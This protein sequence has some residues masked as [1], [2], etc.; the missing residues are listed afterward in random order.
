MNKLSKA[1]IAERDRLTSLVQQKLGAVNDAIGEYNSKVKELEEPVNKAVEEANQAIDEANQWMANMHEQMDAYYMDRSE[2]WQ[3]SEKG[4]LYS[5]W[6][7]KFAEEM[8]QMEMTF[9]DELEEIDDSVE[10][11][12]NLPDQ[13]E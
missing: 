4:M 2:K 13:P 10:M 5:D 6:K 3:E 7:D 12:E 1:D 9:P 11:L 8:E